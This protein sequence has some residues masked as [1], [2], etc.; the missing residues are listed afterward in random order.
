MIFRHCRIEIAATFFLSA[1]VAVFCV[2]P[3]TSAKKESGLG[4]GSTIAGGLMALPPARQLGANVLENAGLESGTLGW[5]IPRCFTLDSAVSHSGSHSLRYD[6]GFL[7]GGFASPPEF[8]FKAGSPYAFSVWAKTSA[9]GN[10]QARIYVFN[11]TDGTLPVGSTAE[12]SV[13]TDWTQIVLRDVDVLPLHDGDK[14]RIRLMPVAPRG[15][16]PRGTL[17]FDDV[18]AQPEMPLPISTFLLYPNFRGYLWQTGS[19]TIRLHV[20]VASPSGMSAQIVLQTEGGSIVNTVQQAAQATQEIDIDGTSLALGSYLI[21]TNLLDSTGAVVSSY[22]DYRVTKVSSTFQASLVNYIDTDNFLVHNGQKEFV[23]GVYDRTSGAY[24][25]QLCMYRTAREYETAIKGFD[26]KGRLQNYQD[27]HTNA[28]INF[29]PWSAMAPGPPAIYDQLDPALEAL[30]H[31]GV[32]YLQTVNNWVKTNR[33]RPF[34]AGSLSDE[35]LW[36]LAGKMMRGKRGG[37]GYYT[38]D[39][40]KLEELPTVFDQYKVLRENN[41]GSVAFGALISANQIFR[42]RD[43]ADAIGCDPYPVGIPINADEY[44][45]GLKL[46]MPVLPLYEPPMLRVPLWTQ[47]TERQVEHARPVWMVLQL[48]RQWGKFPTYDQ[49]KYSAYTS[50]IHGANGIWWWGFVSAQGIE[51]EW[52]ARHN[53]QPYYDFKKL[54]DEV[55]ALNSILILPARSGFVKLPNGSKIQIL[56]KSDFSREVIFASNDSP[57]EAKDVRF[58]LSNVPQGLQ[59]VE[60]YSENRTLP[61]D[62]QDGFSDSFRPYEAHV[63]ILKLK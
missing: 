49:M 11:D 22:P 48:M 56:V 60:V 8:V 46:V 31:Y 43:A 17:W 19:Q 63:Y 62:A 32:G 54:S 36:E 53:Q 51:G 52:Y 39:E 23:W 6:A 29:A 45:L 15:Q 20:E 42:W 12:T 28:L 47:E 24:A 38:F 57:T 5:S 34:W 13:G 37:I 44:A 27:T 33:Y 10:L 30:G 25:C 35:K 18:T 1:V 59:S 41:S 9:G 2:L 26:G 7:C 61:I 50:I 21:H 55:T 58:S 16:A 14:L 40:P 3:K 4:P